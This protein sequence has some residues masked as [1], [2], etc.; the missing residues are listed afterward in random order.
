MSIA[1]TADRHAGLPTT[2]QRLRRGL[3][4][5][6]A[7]L[8]AAC[9][10]GDDSGGGNQ[11]PPPPPAACTDCGAAVITMT[12]AQGDFLSYTVDVTSVKL[13]KANG[14]QVETLPATARIDFA[15]LVDLAE[16]VSAGQIPTGEYVAATLSVDFSNSDIVVENAAGAAV[17]VSPVGANGQALTTAELTVQLDDRKHLQIN[18]NS[19]AQLALDVDLTATNV[20]DLATNKV[21][22]TPVV[23]ASVDRPASLEARARGRLQSVDTAGS[24]Y[25]IKLRPFHTATDVSD[26]KI[27]TTSTTRFEIGGTVSSGAAGLTALAALSGNPVTIAFGSIDSTTHSF[28]AVR[29]LAGTSAEDSARDYISGSVL[30]RSGNTLTVG[31]VRLGRTNG[32][33]GFQLGQYT[34]TVGGST[35]VTRD[36][37]QSGTFG[38][39]D[40]SVGQRIE[41]FGSLSGSA[42]DAS[43]G[44]V[45]LNYTHLAGKVTGTAA[46]GLTLELR[47]I[48]GREPVR[49]NFAGTGTSPA[50][51]ADPANYEVNTGALGA[52]GLTSGAYTRVFGFVTPFGT[53]APDFTADT[54]TNLSSAQAGAVVK[55]GTSGTIAPFSAATG[56]TL[57]LDKTG[58]TGF[59][60]SGGQRINLTTIPNGLLMVPSDPP[61]VL[62]VAHR[63]S[64]TVD[65]YSELADL[66]AELGPQL[67]GTTVMYSL[68]AAGGTYDPVT[69]VLSGNRLLVELSN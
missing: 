56:T 62:A 2:L 31:G 15:Q 1:T 22:V 61:Y 5:L 3:V 63:A 9:G 27:N 12:D 58:A 23:V 54:I 34:V 18:Q 55:W 20:V 28:T 40:I 49:F 66:A 69:N 24:S 37:Q 33:Y 13:K 68:V 26:L 6:T 64:K 8:L 52:G 7:A 32:S 17:E 4:G 47:S 43:S 16:I 65:I 30:S 10:G 51:D 21:T 50:T 41:A 25:T 48:D 39:A 19:I 14:T 29:V 42:L 45:R 57:T 59:I 53:A 38:I 44:R 67:N 46:S 35:A 11:N 60:L 36:G